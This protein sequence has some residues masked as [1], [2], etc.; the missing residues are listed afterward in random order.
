MIMRN[1]RRL[2]IILTILCLSFPTVLSA[3]LPEFRFRKYST[4]DGL[5]SNSVSFV[6]QDSNG[7]IWAGTAD[8]LDSFDGHSFAHPLSGVQVN[9]MVE[10]SSGMLWAGTDEGLYR[11][12][13]ADYALPFKRLDLL[14]DASS[15]VGICSLACGPSGEIWMALQGRGVVKYDPKSGKTTE[16]NVPAEH[17]YIDSNSVLWAALGSKTDPLYCFD[18]ASFRQPELNYVDCVKASVSA[19]CED[20]AGNLWF[21]TYDKGMYLYDRIFSNVSPM[22]GAGSGIGH[23]RSVVNLT[24]P[25]FLAGSDD[26]LL[27]F[28]T[29]GQGSRLY[30]TGS[31]GLSDKFVSSLLVDR[32]GGLWVGTLY[33]GLNYSA[34]DSDA[35]KLKRSA[36]MVTCFSTGQDGHLWTGSNDGICSCQ[37]SGQSFKV[38]GYVNSI[39]CDGGYVWAACSGDLVRYDVKSEKTSQLELSGVNVL[40]RDRK[41]GIWAAN[42][43][44]IFHYNKVDKVFE[45]SRT[46]ESPAVAVSVDEKGDL[47][48]GTDGAGVLRLSDGEWTAYKLPDQYVTGICAGENGQVW[49]SG[50]GGMSVYRPDM[51]KFIAAELGGKYSPLYIACADDQVWISTSRGLLRYDPLSENVTNYGM[52]GAAGD[53]F[54]KGAGM[55]G[56]D[57]KVYLGMSGGYLSF[58]PRTVPAEPVRPSVVVTSFRASGDEEQSISKGVTLSR[59]N[60]DVTI[61]FAVLGY[62]SEDVVEC[63]HFL[64]GVDDDWVSSGDKRSVSYS[65]LKAGRYNFLVRAGEDGKETAL[66]FVVRKSALAGWPA[67]LLLCLLALAVAAFFFLRRYKPEVEVPADEGKGA[68]NPVSTPD[69]VHSEPRPA[70]REPEP[71]AAPDPKKKGPDEEPEVESVAES[72]AAYSS[73]LVIEDDADVR[74]SFLSDFSSG[75]RVVFARNNSEALSILS[76]REVSM[77]FCELSQPGIDGV[78][79]CEKLR[80]DQKTCA[81]PFILMAPKNVDTAAVDAMTCSSDALIRVPY[82]A[83]C[84]RPLVRHLEGMQS[85]YARRYVKMP[86]VSYA[87]DRDLYMKMCDIIDANVPNANLSVESLCNELGI[88]RSGLFAKIKAVSGTTPNNIIQDARLKAAAALLSEGRFSIGDIS[89]IVGFCSPSYFT[90]CFTKQFGVGPR[91]W[92]DRDRS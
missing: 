24:R 52:C 80:S 53:Q 74:K 60:S 12:G 54:V 32:E 91:E 67:A 13:T 65:G 20:R 17:L 68:G 43:S 2:Y 88:S 40:V 38:D 31:A 5:S 42:A 50:R 41:G 56:T 87:S 36:S 23:L 37:A 35:F 34:P 1:L 75:S 3:A 4:R 86:A 9:C 49:A 6:F 82:S 85:I 47:W 46:T 61:S 63:Q 83:E 44:A 69:T 25:V 66:K 8:G 90:K 15:K 11:R 70:L 51:K 57:R 79:M 89:Y 64:R 33:G 21:C 26:G 76:G 28:S 72:P 92:V 14:D 7:F 16:F 84:L 30:V 45:Q 59:K 48:F 22:Q 62:P 55:V 27:C 78:A 19:F 39:L 58:D 71:E 29:S 10:D 73:I 81:I 77:I 18:G